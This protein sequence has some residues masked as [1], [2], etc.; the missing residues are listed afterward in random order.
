MEKGMM[1]ISAVKSL[2]EVLHNFDF[3]K[4]QR[5]MEFLGWEWDG[6]GIPDKFEIESRASD[7]LIEA[8]EKYWDN[9]ESKSPY[10][11]RTS[12]LS[13]SYEY[14]DDSDYDEIE[15]HYFTLEF[16]IECSI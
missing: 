14:I 6:I 10:Y 13:V 11:I 1:C 5:V 7:L 16:V 15:K 3:E 4:V 2:N 12:G 9:S 8:Y